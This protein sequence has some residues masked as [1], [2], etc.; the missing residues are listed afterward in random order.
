MDAMAIFRH[1][2]YMTCADV[3]IRRLGIDYG[4]Q[5]RLTGT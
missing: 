4:E 1:Y 2:T 3:R 5:Q